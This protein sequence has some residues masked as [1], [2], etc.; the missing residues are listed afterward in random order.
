[1][2][3]TCGVCGSDKIIPEVRI[4]DQGQYSDG[5]LKVEICGT[6]NAMIFKDRLHGELKAYICGSCGHTELR[7]I[8]PEALYSKYLESIKSSGS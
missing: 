1:M 7:V 5:K 6:P 8:N 3:L 2:I 4:G